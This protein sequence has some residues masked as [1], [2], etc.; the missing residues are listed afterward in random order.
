MRVSGAREAA[1]GARAE[2]GLEPRLGTGVGAPQA[3]AGPRGFQ[4]GRTDGDADGG[5]RWV[6]RRGLDGPAWLLGAPAPLCRGTRRG[7]RGAQREQSG[8]IGRASGERR[9]PGPQPARRR[10]GRLCKKKACGLGQVKGYLTGRTKRLLE[11]MYGGQ[12]GRRVLVE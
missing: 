11:R 2:Q 3:R 4:V 9:R 1:R 10:R 5:G 7:G 6:W 8:R 12:R